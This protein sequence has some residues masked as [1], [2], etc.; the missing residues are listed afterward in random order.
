MVHYRLR[1]MHPTMR[2]RLE[3][4]FCLALVRGTAGSRLKC[5]CRPGLAPGFHEA[6]TALRSR[7]IPKQVRDDGIRGE[8]VYHLFTP[9]QY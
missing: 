1:L 9:P 3:I 6:G 2:Y 7:E 8:A 4:N 5:K